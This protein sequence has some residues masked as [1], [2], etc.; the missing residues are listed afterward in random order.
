MHDPIL[1]LKVQVTDIPCGTKGGVMINFEKIEVRLE[2]L[3][4]NIND[5]LRFEMLHLY[6][7]I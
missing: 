3:H 2:I 4:F 6:A 5:N 7:L 1:C